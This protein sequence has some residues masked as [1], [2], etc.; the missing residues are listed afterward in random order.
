MAVS[1]ANRYAVFAGGVLQGGMLKTNK[2][3]Q[4]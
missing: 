1:V 4:K 3:Q 2:H